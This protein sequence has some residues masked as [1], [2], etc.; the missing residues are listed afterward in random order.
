M[1]AGS[2]PGKRIRNLRED[3]DL[4]QTKVAEVIGV[5]QRTYS[6]YETGQ[7]AIPIEVVSTLADYYGVSI[8]FLLGRAD[9]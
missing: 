5:S 4:T 3:H 2:D 9:K 6:Y 1:H 7:R 8:N